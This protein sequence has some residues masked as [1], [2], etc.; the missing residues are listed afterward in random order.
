MD[1]P[2]TPPSASPLPTPSSLLL[3]PFSP[4]P[5]LPSS[6]PPSSFLPLPPPSI[7]LPPP[8]SAPKKPKSD[9]IH[10]RHDL[11]QLVFEKRC[12]KKIERFGFSANTG[13][14]KETP[15]SKIP[16]STIKESKPL[17]KK[18][19][20]KSRPPPLF[21]PSSSLPPPPP[22]SNPPPRSS[23]PPSLPPPPPTPPTLP[24]PSLLLTTLRPPFSIQTE[25]KPSSPPQ[26][27]PPTSSLLPPPSPP[28]P[29]PPPPP[30]TSGYHPIPLASKPIRKRGRKKRKLLFSRDSE[31]KQ[32]TKPNSLNKIFH[33]KSIGNTFAT[34]KVNVDTSILFQNIYQMP[35]EERREDREGREEEE[36]RDRRR[37]EEGNGEMREEEGS[38]GRR[39]EEISRNGRGEEE[40]KDGRTRDDGGGIREEGGRRNEERKKELNGKIYELNKENIPCKTYINCDLRYF[41]LSFL[42]E[43]LGHFDSILLLFPAFSLLPTSSSLLPPQ[44]LLTLLTSSL[45]E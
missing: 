25:E 33:K 35:D 39:E 28:P 10:I 41:N 42:V 40:G 45:Y 34:K 12:H 24:P 18:I 19:T 17:P 16:H 27:A 30:P 6:P 31:P 36:K 29:P 23:L 26:S 20:Q 44:F 1:P 4:S 11:N 14:K 37:G 2:Q 5:P 32:A 13:S 9:V 22:S 7:I 21:L 8:P 15:K 43:K 38:N 3:P